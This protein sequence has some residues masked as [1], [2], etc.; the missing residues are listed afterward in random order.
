MKKF[1]VVIV[2][3]AVLTV[4]AV[5]PAHAVAQ[6]NRVLDGQG[7]YSEYAH[8]GW[9]VDYDCDVEEVK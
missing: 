3:S 5:D 9:E 1:E 4:E 7:C 6:A 8:D 2:K